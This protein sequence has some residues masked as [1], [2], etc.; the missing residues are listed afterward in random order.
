M[1]RGTPETGTP[2]PT[3]TSAQPAT[4]PPNSSTSSGTAPSNGPARGSTRPWPTADPNSPSTSPARRDHPS[5]RR[6]LCDLIEEY[7]RHTATPTSSAR[8]STVWSVKTLRHGW[9]AAPLASTHVQ[10][11]PGGQP[12]R[13]RDPGLPRRDRDRR[14]HGGGLP[15][16]G[17]LVRAPDEGRRGLRDRRAR[18]PRAGLPGPGG[19]RRG[20]GEGGGRRGLPG[21]RLP[22]REPPP[23][24][25]VR[26][27]RHHLHRPDGRRAHA[28]RQ[29]GAGDRGGQG[30][31]AYRRSSRC[32]PTTTSTS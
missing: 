15:L 12:W 23:R 19:D 2:T 26:Q 7:G 32:R 5:L 31:P 20:R 21:L 6:L 9:H 4:T 14:A 28:D 18:A 17:P 25:G 13:D 30:R 10:Q 24:R 11:D 27:R 8:P 3:G 29:Q 1:R 16:R 22:L